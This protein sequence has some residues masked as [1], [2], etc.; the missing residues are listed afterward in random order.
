MRYIFIFYL[1]SSESK[2]GPLIV[3][4]PPPLP[5]PRSIP[6]PVR[7]EIPEPKPRRIPEV[8]QMKLIEPKP[9]RIILSHK[10]A[11][12]AVKALAITDGVLLLAVIVSVVV[13]LKRNTKGRPMYVCQN[14]MFL[15]FLCS[16]Y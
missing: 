4:P 3:K 9:R 13:M 12:Q 2:V 16:S 6:E 7:R 1:T 8:G 11:L 10:R 14:C 15:V 5:K